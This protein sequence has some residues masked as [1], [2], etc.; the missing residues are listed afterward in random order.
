MALLED[1]EGRIWA[2]THGLCELHRDPEPDGHITAHLYSTADGL[3]NDWVDAVCQTASGQLWV[4]TNGGLAEVIPAAP[5]TKVAFHSYKTANGL[6][7]Y[8]IHCIDED[9][10]GNLWIGTENRGLMKLALHGLTAYGESD[11]L[12]SAN[13]SSIFESRV[14]DLCV[15][16]NRF[17]PPGV[18][19]LDGDSFLG[20]HPSMPGISYYGWGWNQLVLQ[21][22][23]GCWWLPTGQG[24]LRYPPA[25]NVGQIAHSRPRRYTTKDG[26]PGNDIFRLYEDSRGDIWIA[27]VWNGEGSETGLARWDRSS[28]AIQDVSKS[29]WAPSLNWKEQT[30]S[31]MAEDAS[32]N[33]WFGRAAGGTVMRYRAGQAAL[34]T[35]GNSIPAGQ[36]CALYLDDQKRLWLGSDP[37]GLFR[38]DDP[39]AD[40]PVFRQY[41][42]GT[43]LSSND[44][45]CITQ[46]RQGL[47]YAGT[48]RG[49]D[50]LDPATG[51]AK[52]YTT[53]DGLVSG[54]IT[55]AFRDRR[56]A[57]WF[58]GNLGLSRLRPEPDQPHQPPPIFIRELRVAGNRLP[59]GVV[60]ETE[61]AGL[62][63]G[64]GQNQVQI[65]FVGLGFAIGETLRYQYMLEG[66]DQGWSA[67]SD[68][69]SVNYPGLSPG[70]YR[71]LVR[72]INSDGLISTS[73]AVVSFHILPPIWRRWW[74]LTI[75]CLLAAAGIHLAYRSRLARLVEIERVR[76]R[77]A[78]DLHD[79]IGASLSR[80]AILSE[81]V[82][83]QAGSTSKESAPMLSEIA[84]TARSLVDG[85]SDIVWSIDPRQDD[86]AKLV[87]RVRQFASDLLEPSGATC[88]FQAAPDIQKVKLT[89]EQRRHL[90]LIFKEAINNIARH[91]GCREVK[92]E[93]AVH[94]HQLVVEIRDDGRGFRMPPDE[95][96]GHGLHNLEAR[97]AE[98]GGTFRLESEPGRGTTVQVTV[99]LR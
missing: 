87:L 57:L 67:P 32:G 42:T 60:G 14:G 89:P 3:P 36:I 71:F 24:L 62:E 35:V 65:D 72:A 39:N 70:R 52:H 99:P 97:T 94:D 7:D 75:A 12:S 86:L 34:F 16:Y 77:I 91:A 47:I 22:V 88:E 83:Q 38:V 79:D 40:S 27:T 5:G 96:Q 81:V 25:T 95:C 8:S 44:V 45:Q 6:S 18:G 53:A 59:L 43:G 13:I 68:Q 49:V 61:I 28:G 15:T 66:A 11:G 78:T 20:I 31:A 90:F 41:T 69:L 2:G 29:D 4:G 98:L 76:T 10:E 1:R 74:F 85:M 64:P 23:E 84:D 58:G 19:R 50:S 51:H 80:V 37:G 73:P 93:L 30:W 92:L 17:G 48:G 82:K 33:M 56:G 46:D 21:D 26:L 9:G 54:E 63:L 55:L